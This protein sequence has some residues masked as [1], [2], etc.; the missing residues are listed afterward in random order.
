ME[1]KRLHNKSVLN[2][3][4]LSWFPRS[5]GVFR[6]LL[7]D[8]VLIEKEFD[9]EEFLEGARGTYPY[10]TKLM[11]G[12]DPEF[13]PEEGDAGAA[14]D[15]RIFTRRAANFEL[16]DIVSDKIYKAM[17]ESMSDSKN[18]G[19]SWELQR[20]DVLKCWIHD[21]WT[22]YVD[23]TPS[24]LALPPPNPVPFCRVAVR[25][26]VDEAL[27]VTHPENQGGPASNERVTPQTWIFESRYEGPP[28]AAIDGAP[29]VP[30]SLFAG[31]RVLDVSLPRPFGLTVEE[32]EEEVVGKRVGLVVA[33]VRPG[34]AAERDGRVR[35]GDKLLS[36]DGSSF[37]GLSFDE[38][39]ALLAGRKA[40]ADDGGTKGTETEV[41]EALLRLERPTTEIIAAC[42]GDS[43]SSWTD[44]KIVGLDY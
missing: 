33:A 32:E 36:V 10:V 38:C 18:R 27:L 41:E 37:S 29:S 2:T 21:I 28:P 24:T 1:F 11:L 7:L 40:L 19:I 16:R 22:G 39:M 9:P 3:P 17:L 43:G 4:G 23:E 8:P 25:F 20:C 44:W 5:F 34:G 12:L 35:V 26:I 42:Q 30:A 31:A 14:G 13:S 6:T 15:T